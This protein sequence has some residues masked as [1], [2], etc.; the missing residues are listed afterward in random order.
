VS[1]ST[2]CISHLSILETSIGVFFQSEEGIELLP[3]GLGE[4]QFVGMPVQDSMYSSALGGIAMVVSAAV[5]T[6]FRGRTA[7]FVLDDG[8]DGVILVYDL[9]TQAWS[10]DDY[11]VAIAAVCDTSGGAVLAKRDLATAGFLLEDLSLDQ[12]ST[13]GT[14]TD[15][16]SSLVWAELRP[17][18][19]AGFG[20]FGS[21][22]ALFDSRSA[23]SSGYRAGSATITLSVDSRT[24][25]GKSFTMTSLTETAAY[26]RNVPATQEGTCGAL[27]LSTTVGGWRFVGWTVEA[28]DL[29][30]GRRMAE[31][32]Q[33]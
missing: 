4:P 11:G 18:G 32:E 8:A 3:R 1:G 28:E 30:G 24:E 14:P 2:G 10:R 9:D 33:G 7:R 23:P 22:I 26:Q 19:V 27:T 21:A 12:D 6:T 29:G 20:R 5:V 17:F 25:V 31:T 15:I 13:G 16:A